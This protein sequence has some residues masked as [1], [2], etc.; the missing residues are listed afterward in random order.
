MFVVTGP[1]K[2]VLFAAFTLKIKILTG[3]KFKQLKYL[4]MKEGKCVW[5]KVKITNPYR[6]LT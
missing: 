2:W 1:K 3:L 4:A 6:T 5:A